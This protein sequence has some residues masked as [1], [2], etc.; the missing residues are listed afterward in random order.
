MVDSSNIFWD[1]C[2]SSMVMVVVVFML[3]LMMVMVVCTLGI[4]GSIT[5]TGCSGGSTLF[6]MLEV[7]HDEAA[8]RSQEGNKNV[9]R[10]N[11]VREMVVGR[12]AL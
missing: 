8:F 3:M 2:A 1:D 7:H 6:G 5:A 12:G 10:L 4:R 11:D 9:C